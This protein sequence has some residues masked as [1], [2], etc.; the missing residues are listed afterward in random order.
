[1]KI[2]RSQS[3]YNY[4]S[5]YVIG[6]QELTRHSSIKQYLFCKA[7]VYKEIMGTRA[8]E[9]LTP[10]MGSAYEYKN[11]SKAINL[12]NKKASSLRL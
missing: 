4:E 1:M 9:P 6:R 10:S 3:P 12:R 2:Y 11:A 5:K 7:C 8:V